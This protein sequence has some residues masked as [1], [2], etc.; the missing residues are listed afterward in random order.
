MKPR[1]IPNN[2]AWY[3][4]T[5]YHARALDDLAQAPAIHSRARSPDLGQSAATLASMYRVSRPKTD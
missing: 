3:D 5:I 4:V 1:K 2:H